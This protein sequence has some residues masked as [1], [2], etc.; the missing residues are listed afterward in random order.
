MIA[1]ESVRLVGAVGRDHEDSDAVAVLVPQVCGVAMTALWPP[2]KSRLKRLN[3][4]C[5]ALSIVV[6]T[7]PVCGSVSIWPASLTVT[8]PPWATR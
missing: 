8:P 3:G 4:S 2:K 5:G 6:V 1:N 7:W